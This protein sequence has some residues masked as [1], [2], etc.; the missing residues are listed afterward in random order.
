MGFRCVVAIWFGLFAS[1]S[2]ISVGMVWE[3]QANSCGFYHICFAHLAKK[4]H[5]N[6]ELLLHL[7]EHLPSWWKGT[8]LL[9]V[10]GK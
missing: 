6:H 8:Q 7:F 1:C 10:S 3:I 4:H 5:N 2:G 9:S